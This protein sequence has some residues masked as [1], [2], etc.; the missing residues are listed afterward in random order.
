MRLFLFLLRFLVLAAIVLL[1]WWALWP[2]P[3]FT[4]FVDD[5]DGYLAVEFHGRVPQPD[6]SIAP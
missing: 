5:R 2:R 4:I 3:D 1:L 6:R